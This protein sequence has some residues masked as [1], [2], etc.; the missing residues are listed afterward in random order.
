MKSATKTALVAIINGDTT[1]DTATAAHL[2]KII[3][4]GRIE[5][6]ASTV[7]LEQ[8]KMLGLGRKVYTRKEAAQIL[9]RSP[10]YIDML[11]RQG[12]LEKPIFPGRQRSI[13]ILAS[14]LDKLLAG[15]F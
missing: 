15:E 4:Q 1:I 6:S 8:K 9:G 7:K 5:P 10:R 2:L 13:G 3:Q 12:L 11:A 14:D